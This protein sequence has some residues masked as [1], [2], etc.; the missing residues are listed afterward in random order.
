[1]GGATGIVSDTVAL[2][3][4]SEGAGDVGSEGWDGDDVAEMA[5]TAR[6]GDTGGA[7]GVDGAGGSEV[8]GVERMSGVEGIVSSDRVNGDAGDGGVSAGGVIDG[9]VHGDGTT[10]KSDEFGVGWLESGERSS[11]LS[12]S[13][14]RNS[15]TSFRLFLTRL[16]GGGIASVGESGGSVAVCC[17]G[18]LSQARVAL[19]GVALT[20]ADGCG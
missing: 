6:V 16:A 7:G 14:S 2:A 3:A 10:G 11:S 17:G 19:I 20:G 5:A 12:S 1:M 13:V 8:V 9:G 15:S 18:A 4:G